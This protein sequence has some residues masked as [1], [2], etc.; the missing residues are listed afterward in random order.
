MKL[1]VTQ[2]MI[3]ATIF[4]INKYNYNY[5]E[6]YTIQCTVIWNKSSELVE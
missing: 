3:F 4:Y 5:Y 2:F 6:N 1:I